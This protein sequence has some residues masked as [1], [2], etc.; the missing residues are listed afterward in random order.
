RGSMKAWRQGRERNKTRGFSNKVKESEMKMFSK[1]L[2]VA[3]AA[4][5]TVSVASA[6]EQAYW[7]A[8]GND[9]TSTVQDSGPGK[10]LELRTGPS[11][12]GSWSV[13]M[14]LVSD[15]LITGWSNDM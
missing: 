10:V 3:L 7:S 15:G 8:T 4:L 11:G 6:V 9:G 12:A 13:T 2:V 1:S 5:S 14:H